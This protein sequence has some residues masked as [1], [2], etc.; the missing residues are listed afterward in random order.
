M[1][2][3]STQKISEMFTGQD[4]WLLLPA[5]QQLRSRICIV[6]CLSAAEMI[7]W[8]AARETRGIAWPTIRINLYA[9]VSSGNTWI[10]SLG[11]R[12]VNST[13]FEAIV[14]MFQQRR[15]Y[16]SICSRRSV[17]WSFHVAKRKSAHHGENGA[18]PSSNLRYEAREKCNIKAHVV[19]YQLGSC[20][21]DLRPETCS[22]RRAP[23]RKLRSARRRNT[24]V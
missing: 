2:S 8:K 3:R 11:Q 9:R 6:Y 13:I 24:K 20:S 23:V 22:F 4:S 21:Y 16:C 14:M 7:R 10:K 15:E 18:V 17:Q 19:F 12:L 1:L 5:D